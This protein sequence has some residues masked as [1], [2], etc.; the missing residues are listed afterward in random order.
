MVDRSPPL[1]PVRALKISF[2]SQNMDSPRSR[3]I[4]DLDLDKLTRVYIRNLLFA[5]AEEVKPCS[6][7]GDS[8]S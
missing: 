5:E 8:L 3:D 4:L 7:W 2:P 6:A 1:L